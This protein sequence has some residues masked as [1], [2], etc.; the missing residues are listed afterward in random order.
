MSIQARVSSGAIAGLV[1]G[2]AVGWLVGWIVRSDNLPFFVALGALAGLWAGLTWARLARPLVLGAIALLTLLLIV[3]FVTPSR[4]RIEVVAPATGMAPAIPPDGLT[5]DQA[6]TLASLQ[7]VNDYPLYTMHYSGEYDISKAWENSESSQA[8]AAGDSWAC[9]L[10][11]ALG[12]PADRLY[13]RNFDWRYSPSLLLFTDRPDTDGYSSVSMVDITYFGFDDASVDLT[14]LPLADRRALLEAP[15]WPFDGMNEAGVAVGMAAVPQADERRD[16]GKPFIGSLEVIR[17]IL[18][19]AGSTDEAVAILGRNNVDWKGGLPLHY[20]VA[21]RAGHAALVE[22]HAGQ[23]K[24]LPNDGAWHAATNFTR[25][26]VAG[27]A[28]GQCPRYD[29]LAQRL[30]AA[31]G[32]LDSD[33]AL[34]LLQAV[35][36]TETRTQWSVIYGMSTGQ[37][38][39]VVGHQFGRVYS[40]QLEQEPAAF[41]TT[42]RPH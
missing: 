2:T 12:D 4:V 40:F 1:V 7:K 27:D 14:M 10:F 21:D 28:A 20:L 19:H 23:I 38:H 41:P 26:A 16:R 29:T 39:V 34:D 18:D 17:E 5:L 36:Q 15:S 42:T 37:V 6:A 32:K 35:S 31:S 9:S 30:S 8:F 24:V 22:Y 33:A 25:S 13:G 3:V 11:A